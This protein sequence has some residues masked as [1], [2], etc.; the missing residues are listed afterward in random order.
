VLAGGE[1]GHGQA[2][3]RQ[4]CEIGLTRDRLVEEDRSGKS[5]A[6]GGGGAEAAQP[7]G[8]GRRLRKGRCSTMCCTR[9]FHVD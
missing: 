8:L 7:R 1:V 9:S 2:N 5:P 6:S 3:K 4:G